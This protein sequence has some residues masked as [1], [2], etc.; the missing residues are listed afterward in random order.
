MSPGLKTP[1][2]NVQFALKKKAKN[3][4]PKPNPE[5]PPTEFLEGFSEV[6]K[7]QKKSVILHYS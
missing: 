5:S 7:N 6:C 2:E 1:W 3:S 4:E